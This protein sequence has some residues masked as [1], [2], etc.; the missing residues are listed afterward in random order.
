MALQFLRGSTAENDAYTGPEGSLSI[1]LDLKQ[2]RL[3]DGVTLGGTVIG[4]INEGGGINSISATSPVQISGTASDPI[5]SVN[6][7]TVS[8]DG[9]MLSEDKTKLDGVEAGAEVNPTASEIKALYESNADTNAYTDAEK[10]KLASLDA[11][12]GGETSLK[13]AVLGDSLAAQNGALSEAWPTI[14]KKLLNSSGDL[15][16]DVG[17]FSV[18]GHSYYQANTVASFGVGTTAVDA[19]IAYSP[20]IVIDALGFNDTV[21]NVDARTLTQV[22]ADADTIYSALRGALPSVS[23]LNLKTVAHDNVNGSL[24]S[25]LNRNVIPFSFNLASSGILANSYTSEILGSAVSSGT[26]TGYNNLSELNNYVD[27]LADSSGI[28][29]YWRIGRLGCIGYDTLHPTETGSL[30]QAAYALKAIRQEIPGIVDQDYPEWNDPDTVFTSALSWNGTDYTT[31]YSA[32]VEHLS[33]TFGQGLRLKPDTWYLPTKALFEVLRETVSANQPFSWRVDATHPNETVLS[34]VNGGAFSSLGTST[35]ENGDAQDIAINPVSST[36]VY[37]FRYKIGNEVYGPFSLDFTINPYQIVEGG[38]GA[39]TPAGARVQLGLGTAATADT[40]S[41]RTSSSTTT[42]LQAAGMNSHRTS[43]DHDGRY[44]QL[45]SLPSITQ[46]S[47]I[48][49]WVHDSGY[50][51]A[52]YYKDSQGVVHLVG[53]ADGSSQSGVTAFV[54]PVGYRPTDTYGGATACSGTVVPILVEAN[55]NVSIF[56]SAGTGFFTGHSFRTT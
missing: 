34:S 44:V 37:T 28:M 1:D 54:L 51:R 26:T 17:N 23:I 9:L 56:S 46:A 7:V 15:V 39:T 24:A 55:G 21:T 52:G 13:I 19:C 16:V 5:I 38:T 40:T 48:N 31:S 33:R 18:N 22:K 50:G 29:N 25:L 2:V 3:H 6:G 11:G 35:D 4:T 47:L 8:T 41:S 43:G 32:A 12:G 49:G 42:V 36:G 20:D 27:G 53:A 10:A 30:L 14:L 45:N